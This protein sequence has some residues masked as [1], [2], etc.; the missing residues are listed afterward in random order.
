M[1][2]TWCDK[3]IDTVSFFEFFPHRNTARKTLREEKIPHKATNFLMYNI[4]Y[5]LGN[6]F[7]II[8]RIDFGDLS[9]NAFLIN[10]W[11]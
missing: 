2:A 10:S 9:L 7:K 1:R 3:K 6:D 5:F 11:T 4:V 8:K